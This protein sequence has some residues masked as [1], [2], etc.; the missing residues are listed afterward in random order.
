MAMQGLSNI[1]LVEKTRAAAKEIL[2]K[3]PTLKDYPDL[4]ERLKQFQARIHFE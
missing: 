4:K 1:F 2:E 3:D